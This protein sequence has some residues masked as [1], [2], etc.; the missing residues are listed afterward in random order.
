MSSKVPREGSERPTHLVLVR[1]GQQLDAAYLP[2]Q[3]RPDD[4]TTAMYVPGPQRHPMPDNVRRF[5]RTVTCPE[6]QP[7]AFCPHENGAAWAPFVYM[8]LSRLACRNCILDGTAL[9]IELTHDTRYG[10][11]GTV[12]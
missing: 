8:G 4:D 11:W 5:T 9:D 1:D 10:V 12:A 6:W 3:Q 7:G 2:G